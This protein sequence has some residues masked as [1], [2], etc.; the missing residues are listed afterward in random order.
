MSAYM[1]NLRVVLRALFLF[2]AIFGSLTSPLSPKI[3]PLRQNLTTS[4][5]PCAT[6]SFACGCLAPKTTG[7]FPTLVYRTPYGK[8]LAARNGPR[9]TKPWIAGTPSLF[10]TSAD[11][12]PP[13][14]VRSYQNEGKDGYDTIEWAANQPWSDGNIGTFGLSYPAQCGAGAI[15]TP[16]HLKAMVPATTFSTRETLLGRRVRWL[17]VGVFGSTSRRM[18]QTQKSS[19]PTTYDEARKTWKAEHERIEGFLPLRDLPDLKD[20]SP[21]YYQWLAHPPAD[22]RGTS[23]AM[24]QVRP[25]SLRCPEFL[26]LARRKPWSRQTI[27]ISMVCLLPAKRSKFAHSHDHRPVDPGG[28]GERAVNATSARRPRLITTS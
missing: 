22:P 6:A 19:G 8:H 9:S 17:L 25:G 4:P 7:R 24:D 28:E 13:T 5:C 3:R 18:R 10:R 1:R 21:F 27:Q 12:T 2:A 16:P 23:G 11:D 14:A 26:W 15:E 20:V